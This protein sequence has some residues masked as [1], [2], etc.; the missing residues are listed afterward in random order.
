MKPHNVGLHLR[1]CL[2]FRLCFSKSVGGINEFLQILNEKTEKNHPACKELIHEIV[3]KT[4]IYARAYA[5]NN[6][7]SLSDLERRQSPSEMFWPLGQ[8]P[9]GE[10]IPSGHCQR[11]RPDKC[12]LTR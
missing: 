8:R 2:T 6:N 7:T 5:R 10:H 9:S 4:A 1:N 11:S 12:V 3:T